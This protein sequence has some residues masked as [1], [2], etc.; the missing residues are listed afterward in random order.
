MARGP[1]PRAKL[2]VNGRRSP[3]FHSALAFE[4]RPKFDPQNGP[5]WTPKGT[6]KEALKWTLVRPISIL[7]RVL[8]SDRLPGPFWI[9][10]GFKAS[11]G[12]LLGLLN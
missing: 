5:K 7:E 12:K 8:F 9:G 3:V 2:F 11:K 10:S 1:I 4:K 6:P